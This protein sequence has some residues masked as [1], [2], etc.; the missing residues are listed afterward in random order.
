LSPEDLQH[1]E[2][3][4]YLFVEH[5]IGTTEVRELADELRSLSRDEHLRNQEEM[6]TE[7]GSGAVRSIF[8]VHRLSPVFERLA[9]NVR[10]LDV[11]RQV[12]GSEVYIH[13]SRANFKPGF[14]G[15]EFYWHSDFETWHVEDGMPRMRAISVSVALTENYSFNGPLMV[16][17]GSHKTYV[18]CVGQT[19]EDHYKQSLKKQEYGVPDD[20][21]LR[22]LAEGGGIVA[23]TGPA[24]SAVFFDCNTIHGSNSNI[25]PHPRTNVFFVYNSV[26]N[27]LQEPFCGLEPRPEHIATRESFAPLTPVERG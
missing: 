4:G 6:I 3:H 15:K 19:P 14:M 10:L 24:G 27:A 9:R 23:P 8:R 5:L 11:A 13:Q 18:S 20:E 2:E 25:T 17:P 22:R 26:D 7:P 12:L 21:N 16:M 1:F